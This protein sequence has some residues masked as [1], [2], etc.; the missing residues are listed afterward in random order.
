VKKQVRRKS[1][2]DIADRC[3]GN[4]KAEVRPTKQRELS[5]EAFSFICGCISLPYATLPS[6]IA[7]MFGTS[8]P[9]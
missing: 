4:N 1:S 6:S 9:M 5:R 3:H 7:E 2:Q 8:S